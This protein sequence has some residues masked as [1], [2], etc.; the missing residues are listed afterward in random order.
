MKPGRVIGWMLVLGAAGTLGFLTHIIPWESITRTSTVISSCP[1]D[2]V[3]IVFG[4]LP[5]L[6]GLAGGITCLTE[7]YDNE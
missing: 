5:V 2:L 4:Y 3:V 6:G 7:R 1:P